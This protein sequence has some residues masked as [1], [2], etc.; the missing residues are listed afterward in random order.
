MRDEPSSTAE[1]VCLFRAA[2]RQRPVGT[3]I[4]DDPYAELF[5]GAGTRAALAAFRATGWLGSRVERRVPGLAAF[6]VARHR[7]ID[8]WLVRALE[9]SV[10]QVVLLG[11][12][13]D[14]RAQRFAKEL[15]GRP[16]FELDFPATQRR[17]RR[18]VKQYAKRMPEVDVRWVPIDF[19]SE[20]ID[21]KLL[22]AG[23]RPGARSFFVWEGVSMYLTREAVKETLRAL[24]ALAGL[25]SELAMDWWYLLDD[26]SALGTLHRATPS[27]LH[28]LGEPVTLSLHPEDVGAFLERE[29][30]ELLELADAAALEARY[31]RDDRSVYPATYLVL[32][33]TR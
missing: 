1:S 16:V 6:V 25:G 31:V 13:Y 2:D 32:C 15:R 11:A 21:V 9:S 30:Y 14:T 8:D 18:V 5:L 19:L 24:R 33:R 3:R 22:E 29:G 20:R 12:G 7:Q 10:E 27:L 28:L 17:K 4:L 26:P 23:F